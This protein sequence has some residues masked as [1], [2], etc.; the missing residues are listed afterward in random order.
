M[1]TQQ[2]KTTQIISK[3]SPQAIVAL[4][5]ALSV[6]YWRK[7]DLQD[8]LKAALE[9]NII[10]GTLNWNVMKREV[11]KELIERLLNRQDIY[12][13]DL[14]NLFIAISDFE[15]FSNLDYWDD[16]GSKKK[17]AKD[18]VNK[19]RALTKGF[20]SKTKE[21]EE[22]LKRR[23]DQEKKIKENKSLGEE[24]ATLKERFNKLA[25]AKDLQK[26]GYDL[27]K[28]LYD[29]F[30]LYDL[31]PKGSFKNAGKQIDGA[32]T[33]QG[34]DYLLEAKWKRQVDRNDLS[35]FCY[36]VETKFKTAVGLLVTI[37]GVTKD[38]ISPYFK[39]IIIM[40]GVDIIAI[41]DGRISLIDLLF[42]KR[43]KAIETGNIYLNF[44][45]I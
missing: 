19:L 38:A 18:A 1:T 30:M 34:T 3:F 39:S 31:E 42:K 2:N 33:F 45:S 28:F 10:I 13:N 14:I 25:T 26:R 7:E 41:L 27:E 22:I 20:V 12:R 35:D 43:R 16:D 15:D 11:S 23:A 5:D 4:K 29:L 8:F 40:D 6:I 21:Q 9:N 37:D 44:N 32:F 36:K 17:K 24:L